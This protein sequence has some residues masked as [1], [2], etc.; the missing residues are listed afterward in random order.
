MIYLYIQN[1]YL[2]VTKLAANNQTTIIDFKIIPII[3]I[4]YLTDFDNLFIFHC[5]NKL[6]KMDLIH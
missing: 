1:I 5:K 4:F 3:I 6:L 2:L